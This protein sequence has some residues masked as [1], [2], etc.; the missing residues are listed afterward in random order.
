[1][2]ITISVFSCKHITVT[3]QMILLRHMHSDNFQ[4]TWQRIV[5]RW[6]VFCID[7]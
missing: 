2:Y 5:V 3:V 7:M 4:T 6:S 1:M